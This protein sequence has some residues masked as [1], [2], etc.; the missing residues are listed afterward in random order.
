LKGQRDKRRQQPAEIRKREQRRQEKK[1]LSDLTSKAWHAEDE[2]GEAQPLYEALA[3]AFD[4]AD[5][6]LWRSN[7]FAALRPRLVLHVKAVVAKLD[8]ELADAIHKGK[9]QPFAMWSD[10]NQRKA[11]MADR[12]AEAANTVPKIEAK[13]DR[14]RDIL[15]SLEG[16]A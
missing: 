16:V 10:K 6:E 2:D 15:R 12:K 9:T 3:D 1:Q 4:F 5:P 13:L 14:A 7:S 8:G 11:A